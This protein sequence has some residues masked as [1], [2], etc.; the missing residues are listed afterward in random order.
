MVLDVDPAIGPLVDGPR[1]MPAGTV[2]LLLGQQ[3]VARAP[4]L[5]YR[6]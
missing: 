1:P 5:A 3:V 2:E 4:V 6:P